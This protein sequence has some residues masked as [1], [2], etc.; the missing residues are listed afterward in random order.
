MWAKYDVDGNG[1]L[2]RYECKMFLEEKLGTLLNDN[3]FQKVFDKFDQ[4]GN[5]TI[6]LHE[7]KDFITNLESRK[8]KKR[9]LRE[10]RGD[11]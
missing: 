8:Q 4:D 1:A 3:D 9:V 6:E 2:D 5:G 7:M 11:R 10:Q